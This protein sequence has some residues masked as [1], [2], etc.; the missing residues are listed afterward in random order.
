MAEATVPAEHQSGIAVATQRIYGVE[1]SFSVQEKLETT[2]GGGETALTANLHTCS[3]LTRQSVDDTVC[4]SSDNESQQSAVPDVMSMKSDDSMLPPI[5]FAGDS[6]EN[7]LQRS[8][9]PST[10][11][12]LQTDDSIVHL[13]LRE[14]EG[15]SCSACGARAYK[16]CFTCMAFFCE[17]HTRPHYKGPEFRNHLLVDASEKILLAHP[18][19]GPIQVTS[20]KP[21][22]VSLSWGSHEGST[23][24]QKFRVTWSCDEDQESVELSDL[25]FTVEELIPGK[26]YGFS[27]A[28]LM[29][30]GTQGVCLFATACTGIPQPEDVTV[31]MD[32]TSLTVSWRKPAGVDQVKYLLSLYS[33]GKCLTTISL[34]SPQRCFSELLMGE[35]YTI[36]VCTLLKKGG[37]SN[38]VWKTI[39]TRND[40]SGGKKESTENQE[41]Q[42]ILTSETME[43]AA[44]LLRHQVEPVE[45]VALEKHFESHCTTGQESVSCECCQKSAVKSCLDCVAS[46]CEDHVKKHHTLPKLKKHKLVAPSRDLEQ[47]DGEEHQGQHD[48]CQKQVDLQIEKSEKAS[49]KAAVLVPE[50]LTVESLTEEFEPKHSWSAALSWRLSHAMGRTPHSFQI[51]YHC[52]GLVPQTISS[53]ECDTVITGLRPDTEYTA[54]VCTVFPE[55][56]KSANASITFYTRELRI[57]LLGKTGS[58]KSSTGNTILGEDVFK[59]K[60]CSKSK[61]DKCEAKSKTIRGCKIKII[62]APGLFD[63]NLSEKQL[64]SEITECITECSPGPHAFVFL[65]KV[66]RYTEHEQENVKKI[67]KLFGSEALKHTVLLFTQGDQLDK[68]QTIEDFVK[69]TSQGQGSQKGDQSDEGQTIQNS[70]ERTSRDKGNHTDS[71]KGVVAACGHRYHVIDNR[72]WHQEHEYRSN[73]VQVERLLHTIEEM[74]GKAGGCYTNEFLKSV[75]GNIKEEMDKIRSEV[76]TLHRPEVRQRARKI[77]ERRILGKRAAG[78]TSG[79]LIGGLLGPFTAVASAVSLLVGVGLAVTNKIVK[80]TKGWKPVSTNPTESTTSPTSKASTGE[81]TATAVAGVGT[82]GT[83][84]ATGVSVALEAGVVALGCGIAAGAVAGVCVVAGATRGGVMGADKIKAA[85]SKSIG[86]AILQSSKQTLEENIDIV[87][88]AYT[89][90]SEKMTKSD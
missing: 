78:I 57:V 13:P 58:G 5:N 75:E 27:V 85:E 60:T 34:T 30:D 49:S 1:K 21:D 65:L 84:I 86:E 18:H 80:R 19:F 81:T 48:V 35:E 90:P 22:S 68:G 55:G 26:K 66:D 25:K 47:D 83:G 44:A 74:V 20:V 3:D 89:C 46:Y 77:V 67:R 7:Q 45:N 36:S 38:P 2:F 79:A 9:A 11:S 12:T 87:K 23:G 4:M 56:E 29:D 42:P 43:E 37:Q 6:N 76:P 62:D 69:G 82:T 54:E 14:G 53:D 70:A 16:S 17:C 50:Y 71:L 32:L 73:S 51:S 64:F 88:R 31:T 28:E 39:K 15:V 41:P 33:H 8:I 40:A 10:M 63:T 61:T 24:P 59:V 72:Y 52:E